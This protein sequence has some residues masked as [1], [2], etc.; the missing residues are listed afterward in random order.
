MKKGKY[1]A[2]TTVKKKYLQGTQELNYA[3]DYSSYYAAQDNVYNRRTREQAVNSTLLNPIADNLSTGPIGG[4][5][6]LVGKVGSSLIDQGTIRSDGTQSEGNAFASGA[7]KYG[8]MGAQIGSAAGPIG[9]IV[10]GGIGLIAGGAYSAFQ[11]RQNNR[12]IANGKQSSNVQNQYAKQ[13]AQSKYEYDLQSDINRDVANASGFARRG[14]YKIKASVKVKSDKT[15]ETKLD[16]PNPNR[17][18]SRYRDYRRKP[19]V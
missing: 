16:L 7:L 14:K 15:N 18:K 17:Y 19:K 12:K 13:A 2:K 8:G 10:G 3:P 5:A 11:A 1:K 6:G 9:S 4:A